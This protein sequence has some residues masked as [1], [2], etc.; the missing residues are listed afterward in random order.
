M[1]VININHDTQTA[2]MEAMVDAGLESHHRLIIEAYGQLKRF[3][4]KGDKP[5]SKNGWYVLFNDGLAAGAFGN[6]KTDFTTNWCAKNSAEMSKVERD[7]LKL[8][9]KKAIRERELQCIQEQHN[10]AVKCG[11]LWSNANTLV[12]ANYPYLL[13]KQVRAYGIRQWGE[14]L[15]IPVQDAQNRLVSVQFIMPDGSKK[16]KA[17][18]RVKGC[19]MVIG[20]LEGTVFICEGY[21]T[22]AT[23]HQATKQ[24]VIV[25]F[26]AGNL[27]PVIT[28]L[29]AQG[30]DH[31]K[32]IIVAD[33]DSSNRI[34]TGLIKAKECGN[35]HDLP[36]IYP[37]F[38]DQQKGS[39][40]NDLAC[41]AG[42]DVAKGALIKAL[43]EMC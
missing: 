27:S 39:D 17:G 10:A 28:A 5:G 15:L 43:G 12:N 38:T 11:E 4:V 33:N 20:E 22:G 41:L 31:L 21:A 13:S 9:R 16:F 25:A 34:N 36:V 14:N 19:F 7:N 37:T 26:N 2:F 42:F 23:I 32:I 3:R 6:W 40:F 30:R 24:G 29:Q 1:S 8:Q 18:G 35:Q